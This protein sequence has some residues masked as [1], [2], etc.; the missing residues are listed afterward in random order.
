MSEPRYSSIL[1]KV[2]EQ[3]LY[4]EPDEERC[5]N[6]RIETKKVSAHAWIQRRVFYC[7]RG[8]WQFNV[9]S[10][11]PF[12]FDAQDGFP[13]YYM[14]FDTAINEAEL[15]LR[16]RFLKIPGEKLVRYPDEKLK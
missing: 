13:R 5:W 2:F 9:T 14:K 1:S 15:F 7:D 6:M 4:W 16:W 12:E 10:Q 11:D 8:H 3:A